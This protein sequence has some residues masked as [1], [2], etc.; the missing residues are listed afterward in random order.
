M[1]S[2]F[3]GL[4]EQNT[5]MREGGREG[6]REGRSTHIRGERGREG[7]REGTYQGLM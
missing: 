4:S 1:G 2:H 6:G 7:A 5:M 3:D